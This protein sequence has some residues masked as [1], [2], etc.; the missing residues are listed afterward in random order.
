ML[1]MPYRFLIFA[2]A[3]FFIARGWAAVVILPP[4]KNEEEVNK[5]ISGAT[6]STLI[7]SIKRKAAQEDKVVTL[8]V[9]ALKGDVDAILALGHHYYLHP[10]LPQAKKLAL[11]WWKQAAEFGDARAMA[12]YGYLISGI[13]GGKRNFSEARQWLRK[14]QL[15]GLVRATYLLALIERSAG[16]PKKIV[17]ARSLL[18][19]AAQVGDTYAMN[20]LGVELEL[21]GKMSEAAALYDIAGQAGVVQA[22]KNLQ[23]I[24]ANK[25][26]KETE[27]LQRLRTLAEEGNSQA[28]LELAERHHLGEGVQTDYAK[29]ISYYQ[30]AADAGSQKARDFL[31]LFLVSGNDDVRQPQGTSTGIIRMQEMAARIQ[32]AALWNAARNGIKMPA[33]PIRIEDPL[34]DLIDPSVGK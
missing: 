18:Q 28:L 25:I 16:G 33:R 23:R 10:E 32:S 22:Q 13:T 34:A 8:S 7:D 2:L 29:A 9:N 1:K 26:G 30:R 19:Q 27:I 20:D 21:V 3:V 5:V 4:S 17:L 24:Q 6:P 31:A 15:L 12:A 11:R 14:S